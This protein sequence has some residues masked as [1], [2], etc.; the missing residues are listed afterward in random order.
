MQPGCGFVATARVSGR[1]NFTDGQYSTE[2]SAPPIAESASFWEF[3]C[4][5]DAAAGNIDPVLVGAALLDKLQRC[6]LPCRLHDALN[7]RALRN[8]NCRAA[9]STGNARG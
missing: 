8:G 4:T 7:D 5:W 1:Q 9:D 3:F 2:I 6:R